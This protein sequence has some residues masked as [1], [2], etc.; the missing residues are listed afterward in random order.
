LDIKW[1]SGDSGYLI[2]KNH[3]PTVTKDNENYKELIILIKTLKQI[4]RDVHLS[5]TKLQ[6]QIQTL[7]N[8]NKY[9]TDGLCYKIIKSTYPII[10]NYQSQITT[11]IIQLRELIEYEQE[12]K[13]IESLGN[14]LDDLE[15]YRNKLDESINTQFPKLGSKYNITGTLTSRKKPILRSEIITT[16]E[17][18]ELISVD[19][20]T[21]NNNKTIT[22]KNKRKRSYN[23]SK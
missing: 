20:T 23:K 5:I 8:E 2:T 21:Y 11:K 10:D 13:I 22:K 19:P 17:N 14:K 3:I 12:Q 6:D 15:T 16:G 9:L 1:N 18:R 4:N 7:F